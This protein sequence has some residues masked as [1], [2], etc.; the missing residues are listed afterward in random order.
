MNSTDMKAELACYLRFVRQYKLVL[1]EQ[2]DQD[3]I[4]VDS[5]RRVVW[6]EVKVSIADLMND[7][8]KKLHQCV[9]LMRGLPLFSGRQAQRAHDWFMKWALA[10]ARFFFAVPH[11]LEQAAHKKIIQHYPWAGLLSVQPTPMNRLFLGH[12]VSVARK[13]EHLH[14]RKVPV[15]SMVSLVIC[16]SASL[17]LAY[18][19]LSKRS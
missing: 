3:V 14:D 17:A 7:R 4:A 2:L 9:R 15:D 13:A 18:A 8:R 5:R 19:R 10:P 1:V 16:Q 6:V 12:R 11:T